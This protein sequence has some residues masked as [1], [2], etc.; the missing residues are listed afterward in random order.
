MSRSGVEAKLSER[1]GGSDRLGFRLGA[2][3]QLVEQ[4]VECLR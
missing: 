3:R 4:T 1:L 2:G